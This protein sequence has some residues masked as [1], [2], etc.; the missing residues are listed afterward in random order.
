[1][2]S[3]SSQSDCVIVLQIKLL[4]SLFREASN[5]ILNFLSD[6]FDLGNSGR[7]EVYL[8]VRDSVI[9]PRGATMTRILVASLTGA[10]PYS[11]LESV[12]L[13]HKPSC[14]N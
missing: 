11:R 12:R 5:S 7:G 1:M 6:L 13:P 4:L 10:L 3:E 8:S 14:F 9:I 2:P